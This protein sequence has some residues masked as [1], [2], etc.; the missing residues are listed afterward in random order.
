MLKKG[1]EK[2]KQIKWGGRGGGRENGKL[3]KH[4]KERVREKEEKEEEVEEK[5][6][7]VPKAYIRET[8]TN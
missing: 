6:S 1:R 5:K 2:E 7:T 8:F 4:K 3:K